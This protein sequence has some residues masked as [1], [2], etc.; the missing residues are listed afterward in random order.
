MSEH[1]TSLGAPDDTV[2][3]GE[4]T[5][6]NAEVLKEAKTQPGSDVL[7]SLT[8]TATGLPHTFVAG[9]YWSNEGFRLT[10]LLEQIRVTPTEVRGHVSA[11]PILYGV[12]FTDP[13]SV[14]KD[15]IQQLVNQQGIGRPAQPSRAFGGRSHAFL[16]EDC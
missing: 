6:K 4:L 3:R 11:S 7:L 16:Q 2:I 1:Q 5:L 14:W 15:R 12:G 9:G 13:T 8:V 10:S